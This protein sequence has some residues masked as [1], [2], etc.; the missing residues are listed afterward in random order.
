MSFEN[1]ILVSWRVDT[2]KRFVLLI[3]DAETHGSRF[4]GELVLIRDLS[5]A[6]LHGSEFH[7]ELTRLRD[8]NY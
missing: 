2:G 4:H 6:E 1:T 5:D 7:G 3:S 8:L